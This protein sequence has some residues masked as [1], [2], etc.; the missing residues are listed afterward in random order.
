MPKNLEMKIPIA[1]IHDWK[2]RMR[3]LGA[4]FVREAQQTDTYFTVARGRLKLR[5]VSDS[6][7]ELIYYDR[8]ETEAER[9]SEYQIVPLR[10]STGVKALLSRA[11]GI[12]VVVE[13]RRQ[14]YLYKNAR[15]HLDLVTGLGEFLELEVKEVD[16]PQRAYQLLDFLLKKLSLENTEK[17]KVSYSDL[18]MRPGMGGM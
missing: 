9:W 5:E 8:D 6:E 14:T 17:V 3:L 4:E 16:G 10:D 7:S 12:K 11:L 2:G 13:K 18:I 15:I 1:A